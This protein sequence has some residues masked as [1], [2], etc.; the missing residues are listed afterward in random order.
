MRVTAWNNGLHHRSGTGY[1]L[2][3]SAPD[4]D[5]HFEPHWPSVLLLLPGAENEIDVN[6]AKRSFW[7]GK[8]GELLHCE[9]GRWL[10]GRGLAPWPKRKPP[11]FELLP[12]GGNHFRVEEPPSPHS[13]GIPGATP[14]P[15]RLGRRRGKA[16]GAPVKPKAI[17]PMHGGN[18][19]PA[20]NC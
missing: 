5:R 16:D 3:V 6:I 17:V 4:R 19:E 8:C 9:I 2:R 7:S 11:K 20:E 10:R 13:Y 1:G 18:D 15:A 14:G 12:G